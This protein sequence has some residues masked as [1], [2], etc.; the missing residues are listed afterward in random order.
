M[1]CLYTV[2]RQF[3]LTTGRLNTVEDIKENS[4]ILF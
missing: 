2:Y 3:D 1:Y 4:K